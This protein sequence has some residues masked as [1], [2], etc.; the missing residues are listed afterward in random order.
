MVRLFFDLSVWSDN[1]FFMKKY[2][3]T[4]LE[5]YYGYLMNSLKDK[6][7]LIDGIHGRVEGISISN[8][9][10][11]VM[12]CIYTSEYIQ[13]IGKFKSSFLEN[14]KNLRYEVSLPHLDDVEIK[15]NYRLE[16]GGY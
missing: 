10:R 8:D 9:K 4:D 7:F 14:Y 13:N 11:E 15:Y 12:F 5:L 3:S 2:D 16:N 6:T 1:D